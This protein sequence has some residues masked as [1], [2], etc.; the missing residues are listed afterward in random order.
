MRCFFVEWREGCPCGI[1]KSL[2]K[3]PS[4]MAVSR[5]YDLGVVVDVGRSKGRLQVRH[6]KSHLSGEVMPP[7]IFCR[8]SS[9]Q[10]GFSCL[11]THPPQTGQQN[12]VACDTG[13]GVGVS[14]S[15]GKRNIFTT[16]CGIEL[17]YL[18]F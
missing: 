1:K 12:S 7:Q 15:L 18:R 9:L 5:H 3:I 10:A 16:P 2:G 13:K 4:G 14:S 11:T 8:S 6:E 17:P